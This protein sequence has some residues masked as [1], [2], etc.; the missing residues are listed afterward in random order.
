MQPNSLSTIGGEFVDP[1]REAAFQAERLPET[2][3]HARLLFG[4][5]AILNFLFL[6]SDW[7]F[8]GGPHFNVA[9]PARLGVV[10]ISLICLGLAPRASSFPALQRLILG[11]E[12]AS[13]I[14]V[15]LLVSS[16][17]DIALFVVL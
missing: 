12:A 11:W 4:L 8:A 2:L 17:S 5:A 7:R 10:V 14:G 6:V 15:A 3:R 16:R 1:Q 9:V 13:A